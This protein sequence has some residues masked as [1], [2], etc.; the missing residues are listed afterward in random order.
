MACCRNRAGTYS[1]LPAYP[2]PQEDVT[3]VFR[4]VN[5]HSN[6]SGVYLCTAETTVATF[7]DG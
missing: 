6:L 2:A 7:N 4:K 5:A 1:G 3:L